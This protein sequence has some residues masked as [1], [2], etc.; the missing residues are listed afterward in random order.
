MDAPHTSTPLDLARTTGIALA[1]IGVMLCLDAVR[2]PS[3][4]AAVTV[5]R[6]PLAAAGAMTLTLYTAH[7][8]FLNSPFDIYAPVPGYAV[9]VVAVLLLGLAWRAT[10]GRGPLETVAS[11]AGARAARAVSPERG[12]TPP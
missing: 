4:R 9:Q 1:V 8:L 10:A 5:L 7:V 11:A 12:S 6:A 3:L 2:R